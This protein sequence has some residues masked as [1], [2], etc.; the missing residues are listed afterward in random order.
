MVNELL[1]DISVQVPN[2]HIFAVIQCRL[3]HQFIDFLDIQAIGRLVSGQAEGHFENPLCVFHKLRLRKWCCAFLL[4]FRC[5]VCA[6]IHT[7]IDVFCLD[8]L[9]HLAL[10]LGLL[11][12]T[13]GHLKN[14]WDYWVPNKMN[15]R[16]EPFFVDFNYIWYSLVQFFM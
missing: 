10:F 2:A 15:G 6:Q 16:S 13:F 4:T 8:G 11:V 1:S 14:G 5:D 3:L 9:R 7:E 12:L